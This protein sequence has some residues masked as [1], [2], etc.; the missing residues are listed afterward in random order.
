MTMTSALVERVAALFPD[1]E[2]SNFYGSSE[3][4]TFAVR[5][6]AAGNPGSAGRPGHGQMLRVVRADSERRV[7]PQETVPTG[8]TGEII[9]NS[10]DN[11]SQGTP[12]ASY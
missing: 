9:A 4:Y 3:I 11:D 7:T 1:A 10:K 8:E 5:N 12:Y 2:F 6:D